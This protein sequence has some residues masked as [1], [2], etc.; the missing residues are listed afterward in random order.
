MLTTHLLGCGPEQTGSIDLLELVF[1]GAQD[2]VSIP[3][4]SYLQ[5]TQGLVLI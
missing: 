3:L 4:P 1:D 5:Q 2:I